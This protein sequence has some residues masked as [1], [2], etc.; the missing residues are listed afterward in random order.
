MFRLAKSILHDDNDAE[1]A[2]GEAILKAYENLGSLRSF[3]SFKPWIMKIV[4]RQAYTLAGRRQ[5]IVYMEDLEIGETEAE[6]NTA[7]DKRE[8][9]RVV[10]L[11][12]EQFR[13]TTV[14]YYYEDMSIKEIAKTL[15]LPAGTVKSRLARAREKLKGLL[16]VEGGM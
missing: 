15:D 13:L 8:L 12:E 5:R 11:L 16:T 9:W 7:D 3:K 4:L 1:D 14:L 10:H 2:T 6:E